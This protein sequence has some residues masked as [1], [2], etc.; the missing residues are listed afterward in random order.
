MRRKKSQD[1]RQW[2]VGQQVTD[3]VPKGRLLRNPPPLFQNPGWFW[4]L[5]EV[6]RCCGSVA[7]HVLSMYILRNFMYKNVFILDH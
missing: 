1:E 4:L 2:F 7:C 5:D 3:L 6:Q